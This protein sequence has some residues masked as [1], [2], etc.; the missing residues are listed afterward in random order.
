MSNTDQISVN[1][2]SPDEV[3][4]QT[5]SW[6]VADIDLCAYDDGVVTLYLLVRDSGW[7][8]QLS[9]NLSTTEAREL[10][11]AL[12]AAAQAADNQT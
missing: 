11:A 9:R 8:I 7:S 10:G 2:P 12:L 3:D 4:E 1:L 5:P 6:E